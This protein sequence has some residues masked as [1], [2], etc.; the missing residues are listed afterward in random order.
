MEHVYVKGQEDES[1]VDVTVKSVWWRGVG[2]EGTHVTPEEVKRFLER[3]AQQDFANRSDMNM[4][5]KNIVVLNIC[6]VIKTRTSIQLGP[7]PFFF[8]GF[9]ENVFLCL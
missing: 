3:R 5:A 6:Q 4:R 1:F 9:G 8:P 2:Y 7:M